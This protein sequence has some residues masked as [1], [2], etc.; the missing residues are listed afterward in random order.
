[1]EE[2][3]RTMVLKEQILSQYHQHQLGPCQKCKFLGPIPGLQNQKLSRRA[4][5]SGISQALQLT[6]AD[7]GLPQWLRQSFITIAHILLSRQKESMTPST[8]I[9]SKLFVAQG[10]SSLTAHQ[11]HLGHIQNTKCWAP[12]P[13]SASTGSVYGLG[14][15]VLKA[16]QVN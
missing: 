14:I 10:C 2:T 11:N 13:E 3:N 16:L 6:D 4:L 8:E 15:N 5:P 7:L 9:L 12:P 1:M